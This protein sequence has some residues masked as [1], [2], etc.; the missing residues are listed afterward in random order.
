MVDPSPPISPVTAPFSDAKAA[1]R[2]SYRQ[3]RAEH[4]EGLPAGLRALMLN[5]PPAPVAEQM[6]QGAVV[7]VYYPTGFEASPLGWAR[8]LSEN[9]R[10]VALPFF[11]TRGGP[12]TFRLWDNPWDDAVLE[13]G[14]WRTLQPKFDAA[15]AVPSVLVVPLLAFTASGH[16]LGQGGGH[17]DRWLAAHPDTTAIGLAWDCQLADD[18]PVEAHDRTLVSIVTPTRIYHA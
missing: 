8:W 2:R 14:P 13:P 12:M 15:A 9:G 10:Q 16:R 3:S 17:Y 4:V 18:L 5:R 6:P 7:G 11:E 1:L